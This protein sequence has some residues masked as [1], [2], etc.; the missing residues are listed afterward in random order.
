MQVS[1][2]IDRLGG[3]TSVA[4]AIGAPPPTVQSWKRVNRIPR[5]RR[6]AVARLAADRQVTLPAGFLGEAVQGRMPRLTTKGA[7]VCAQ[8]TATLAPGEPVILCAL[9]ERPLT[10]ARLAGCQYLDCPSKEEE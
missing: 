8:P 3:T 9:C 5:W 10:P 4:N 1:D 2:I 7:P 6:E